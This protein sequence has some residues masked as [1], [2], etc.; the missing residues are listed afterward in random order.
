MQMI[1]ASKIMT[2]ELGMAKAIMIPVDKPSLP[3][4]EPAWSIS[5]IKM[6][7]LIFQF[8]LKSQFINI[9][10]ST[11]IPKKNKFFTVKI[12]INDTMFNRNKVE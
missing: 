6:V 9:N 11:N 5:K 3:P 4:S 7:L 12:K 10:I 1:M 2:I 8:H